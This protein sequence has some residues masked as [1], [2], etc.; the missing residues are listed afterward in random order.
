[1]PLGAGIIAGP[2]PRVWNGCVSVFW[3]ASRPGGVALAETWFRSSCSRLFPAVCGTDK[4]SPFLHLRLYAK[5]SSGC[6]RSRSSRPLSS[7]LGPSEVLRAR[8]AEAP[9]T[10]AGEWDS[11][12]FTHPCGIVAGLRRGLIPASNLSGRGVVSL[13]PLVGTAW[14][15]LWCGLVSVRWNAR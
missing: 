3:K 7:Q 1:M 2:H 9:E 15:R 8:H 12:G 5:A 6:R 10:H 14:V 11:K 4:G 13:V